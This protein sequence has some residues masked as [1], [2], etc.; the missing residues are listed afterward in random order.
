MSLKLKR[1][2]SLAI[3]FFVAFGMLVVGTG[4]ASAASGKVKVDIYG[5][6]SGKIYVYQEAMV[7]AWHTKSTKPV[8]VK[9]VKVSNKSIVKLKKHT[10]KFEGKKYKYYTVTGKKPGKV[11]V[12]VKYSFKGKTATKKKYVTVTEYPNMIQSL[13]VNGKNISF[14]GKHAFNYNA[15]YSKSKTKVNIKLAPADGWTI[16]DVYANKHYMKNKK[17]KY[18]EIKSA[19]SKITNGKDISFTKKYDNLFIGITLKSPEGKYVSYY[20]SLYR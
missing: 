11:K 4:E 3:A 10:Y 5:Y 6:D 7:D 16:D 8:T 19:K 17:D 2:M 9:S 18:V 20:I 1:F 12:T 15:K 14:K 13:T